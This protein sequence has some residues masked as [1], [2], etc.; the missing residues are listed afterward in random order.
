MIIYIYNI[1]YNIYIY[2]YYNSNN[3]NNHNMPLVENGD[4]GGI[5]KSVA[6]C[7]SG[8]RKPGFGNVGS[9]GDLRRQGR[10]PRGPLWGC[11]NQSLGDLPRPKIE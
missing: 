7:M 5:S 11:P 9:L 8:F 4:P 10:Y 2:I 6:I 1:I 3:S